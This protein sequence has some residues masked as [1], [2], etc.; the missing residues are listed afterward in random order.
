[1]GILFVLR[2]GR[3]GQGGSR[4]GRVARG[5]GVGRR[6]IADLDA[7]R[8]ELGGWV[9]RSAMLMK[10]VFEA[11]RTGGRTIVFAEGEDERVLRTAQ[12]MLQEGIDRPILIGRPDVIAHRI[13]RAGR[14]VT[15]GPDFGACVPNH[16]PRSRH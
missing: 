11:A 3:R 13:Q 2:L 14:P 9:F 4:G 16:D 10:P 7:Y 5:T 6:P 1:M 15:P 12:S 8:G